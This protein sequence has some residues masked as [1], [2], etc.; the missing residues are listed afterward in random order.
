MEHI[1]KL[2]EGGMDFW[3]KI[4]C[5][6]LVTGCSVIN[7]ELFQVDDGILITDEIKNSPYAM[8]I[9]KIVTCRIC[10]L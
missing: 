7:K 2:I 1:L 3:I 4:S 9:V 5:I 10:T 6:A 8:Q